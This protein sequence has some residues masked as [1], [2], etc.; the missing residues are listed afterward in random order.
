M[1]LQFSAAVSYQF[2]SI[3]GVHLVK[4]CKHHLNQNVPNPASYLT[5]KLKLQLLLQ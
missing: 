2:F 5:G 3:H 1:Q 4:Y